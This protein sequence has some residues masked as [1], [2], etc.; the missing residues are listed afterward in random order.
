MNSKAKLKILILCVAVFSLSIFLLIRHYMNTE[1][2]DI[3]AKIHFSELLIKEGKTILATYDTVY[4]DY[5]RRGQTSK[6]MTISYF[7]KVKDKIYK[8]DKQI[9]EVPVSDTLS[10]VYLP[11]NPNI[12]SEN[13]HDDLEYQ[14][15]QLNNV[16]GSFLGWF[17]LIISVSVFYFIRK[18]YLREI[19][20]QLDSE[21]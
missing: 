17:L 14:K 1:K 5:H 10:V 21:N 19:N 4:S 6:Y 3:T 12:H 11:S 13:A 9:L 8:K 2:N 18:Y 7:Y 20:E 16:S 15:K